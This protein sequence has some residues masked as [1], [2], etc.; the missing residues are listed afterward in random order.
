MSAIT[1]PTHEHRT[2]V[3]GRTGSG[4]T[5]WS[6]DM[7][8]TRDFDVRPWIVIDYKREK[9]FLDIQKAVGKD[10]FRELKVTDKLPKKPG[11]Y[12]VRPLPVVDDEAV[13]DMLMRIWAEEDV[14]V[15]VDEGFALP[16]AY[17]KY[18]G[19]TILLTQGRSKG[20]PLILLYQRPTWMNRF[21]VAQADF[22]AVFDQNDIRDVKEVMNYIRP[23]LLPNGA[24]VKPN[25]GL[26]R[27]HSIWYE[28]GEGRASVLRP[29]RQRQAIIQ[30]FRERLRAPATKGTFI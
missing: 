2:V 4:K 13:E 14:G 17:P 18:K 23:V 1:G 20:I 10:K 7:L 30:A 22:F 12:I 6:A 15:Y 8:S 26:P 24:H 11:L 9:I 28:V 27:F 19:L 21:A 5:Q 25:E 16:Q 3:I 29:A